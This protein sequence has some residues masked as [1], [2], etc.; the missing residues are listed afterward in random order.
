VRVASGLS[1]LRYSLLYFLLVFAAG[2][3]LGVIRV[4]WLAPILGERN[5]ELAEIPVMLAVITVA[6]RVVVGRMRHPGPGA[7][8]ATGA[9]ALLFMLLVE[10]TVVL[11]LRGLTLEQ[12]LESRDPVAGGAYALSLLLFMLM[13]A[14]L[15]WRQEDIIGTRR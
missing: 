7:R 6:A 5:A 8:L 4:L 3:A 15:A 13:P 10:F 12:Y 9:L 11:G 1:V 14:L 2:F